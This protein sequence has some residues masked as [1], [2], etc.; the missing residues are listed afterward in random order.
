MRENFDTIAMR[1]VAELRVLVELCVPFCKVIGR[2]L[3][4][5][6]SNWKEESDQSQSAI[7]I[8]GLELKKTIEYSLKTGERRALLEF[9]KVGETQ[10]LFPRKMSAIL[11]N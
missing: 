7:K 5:K 10:Q 8:L 4:Y 6:G 9:R 1:A 3:F 11:K 2:L